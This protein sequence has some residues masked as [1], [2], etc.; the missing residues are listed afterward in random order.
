MILPFLSQELALM[1]GVGKLMMSARTGDTD[2]VPM[3]SDSSFGVTAAAFFAIV[4]LYPR[5][6]AAQPL[7]FWA[8]ILSVILMIVALSKPD[9]LHRA[10][11]VWFLFGKMLH[12]VISPIMLAVF[13]YGILCPFGVIA[14]RLFRKEPLQLSYDMQAESYWIHR[15][16][17]ETS[18]MENQF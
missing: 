1:S 15:S 7:R 17:P 11:A 4:A 18:S 6:F 12:R 2:V 13:F 8:L 16:R 5:L 3:P 9:L 14:T 10:N